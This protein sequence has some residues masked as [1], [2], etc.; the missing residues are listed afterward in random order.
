MQKKTYSQPTSQII[1]LH[2]EEIIL[3][4]SPNVNPPSYSDGEDDWFT[5]DFDNGDQDDFWK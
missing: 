2:T 4:A 5:D 3:A 1:D